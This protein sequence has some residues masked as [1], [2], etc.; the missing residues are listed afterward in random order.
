MSVISSSYP[1]L[2]LSIF[3]LRVKNKRDSIVFS[4]RVRDVFK[5]CKKHSRS[6]DCKL[7]PQ[8]LF[9][10]RKALL[11]HMRM[12]NIF[13]LLQQTDHPCIEFTIKIITTPL[14]M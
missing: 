8:P 7:N 13:I 12:Q 1:V 10:F 5:I 9:F 4:M 11:V 2:H 6:R 3:S 14:F